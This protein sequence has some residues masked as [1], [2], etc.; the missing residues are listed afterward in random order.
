LTPLDD[1]R[2]TTSRFYALFEK[3]AGRLEIGRLH[4]FGELGVDSRK[5]AQDIGDPPTPQSLARESRR[6][7]KLQR[8]RPLAP[9]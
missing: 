8:E 6:R 1:L 7:T 5:V 4:A 3:T 2:C 9:R